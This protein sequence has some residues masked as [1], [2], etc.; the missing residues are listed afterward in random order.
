MPS[1]GRTATMRDLEKEKKKTKTMHSCQSRHTF[2]NG[3]L[4]FHHY[5]FVQILQMENSTIR[6]KN[7]RPIRC[8]LKISHSQKSIPYPPSYECGTWSKHIQNNQFSIDIRNANFPRINSRKNESNIYT[9][10]F[11]GHHFEMLHDGVKKH[12][13]IATG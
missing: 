13:L 1:L 9:Y 12:L 3:L 5:E 6:F 10:L 4:F 2:E 11:R 8:I 7:R